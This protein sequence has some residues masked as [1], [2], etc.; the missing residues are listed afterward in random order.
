MKVRR[1]HR[2]L[3]LDT[4]KANIDWEKK[5]EFHTATDSLAR[6]IAERVVAAGVIARRVCR[7]S[8]GLTTDRSS[9]EESVFWVQPP[10]LNSIK[11]FCRNMQGEN[12][13]FRTLC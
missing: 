2:R 13:D 10:H 3:A 7:G 9:S 1:Y 8:L 5:T 4:N 11:I 12:P 6:E